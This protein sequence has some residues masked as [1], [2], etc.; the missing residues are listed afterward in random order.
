MKMFWLFTVDMLE[1]MC[2]VDE[3][4]VEGETGFDKG[5]VDAPA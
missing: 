5:G 2:T 4:V 1:V 3:G